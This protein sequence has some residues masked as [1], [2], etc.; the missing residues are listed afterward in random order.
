MKEAKEDKR[1]QT[2]DIKNKFPLLWR[3]T[4]TSVETAVEIDESRDAIAY[5]NNA[6]SYGLVATQ[7]KRF[8]NE[9]MAFSKSVDYAENKE[10]L[11]AQIVKE[12][13]GKDKD[14]GLIVVIF[15]GILPLIFMNIG[16]GAELE[17]SIR[18]YKE[19]NEQF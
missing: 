11:Q 6:F 18:E 8:K 5:F 3:M 12:F 13:E 15:K 4:R 16:G 1:G 14:T 9:A 10:A 7:L 2:I 17:S 19:G